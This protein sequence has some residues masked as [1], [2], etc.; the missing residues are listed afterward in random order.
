MFPA[1]GTTPVPDLPLMMTVGGLAVTPVYEGIPSWSVGVLQIN[2]AVP[3]TL[4]AGT[5][6]V[7]VTIGGAA[8]N[9]ALLTIKP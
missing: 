8:S 1:A 3:S 7:V 5:Y 6:P 4:A 9:R 2:F